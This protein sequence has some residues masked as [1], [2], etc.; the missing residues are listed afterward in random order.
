MYCVAC[1]G[2]EGKGMKIFGTP[3]LTN[4]IWLYGNTRDRIAHTIR[5]GRNGV[6][7]AFDER[8]GRDKVHLVAG[9]VKS[10]SSG[11]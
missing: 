2:P 10:L 11:Q 1:H 8:L 9:Y 7:P 4:E 5:K 6:M 3:D